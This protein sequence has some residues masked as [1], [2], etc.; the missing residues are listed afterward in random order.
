MTRGW[1]AIAGVLVVSLA[2][3]GAAPATVGTRSGDECPPADAQANAAIDYVPFVKVG[4][5]SFVATFSPEVTI[6][7][8]QLGPSVTTV[9][10]MIS[11]V[12][13][14]PDFE[15]RDGDAAY[16]PIG[17][18]LRAVTGYRR[19]F[20]LAANENGT[21]RV[22]EVTDV[23]GAATGADLLDLAGK[24]VKVHLVEGDRGEDILETVDDPARVAALVR[25]V[26]SS[27]VLPEQTEMDKRLGDESPVFI[28]FDLIDGT[29]V[30][31]AWHVKAG[32]LAP[33]IEA[34]PELSEA[35]APDS[36]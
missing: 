36:S 33:R 18:E 3:C 21:W 17:T 32:V 8:S 24:V 14:N 13:T 10:C 23:P 11:E 26:L 25:A 34:P 28:R 31:R 7:R 22:Y 20:R 27:P 19:D 16:L 6:S 35:L 2:G 5:L 4:E 29:A 30:Q 9:R 12:V 1:M 15:P